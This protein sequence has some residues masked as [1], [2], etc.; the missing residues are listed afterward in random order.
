MNDVTA[1][2]L[3]RMQAPLLLIVIVYSISIVGL[4]MIPGV[5]EHGNTWHMSI[6]HALYFVSYTATTIGFGEIPYPM[7]DAQRLWSIAIIYM[8][9]ISWFYAL[10]TVIALFQDKQFLQE[11]HKLAFR[12]RVRGMGHPYYVVC[13]FGETG[14]AVVRALQDEHYGAVVIEKEANI[15]ERRLDYSVEYVPSLTADASE[16]E[17]LELA[18]VDANKCRGVIAVTASD[19]INLQIAI[20][21]KLLHPNV[22]VICRSD[23]K[24]HEDNMLSFGTDHIINPFESFADTFEMALHSPSTHLIYD[25]L[26]GAPETSLSTPVQIGEGHWILLGYGRFGQRIHEVLSEK[27]IRTVVVEPTES[28]NRFFNSHNNRD[29]FI[30]GNGTD[31]D[32]LQR[33]GIDS[34][35]GVIAGSNNDANNLSM[36]M[37]ARQLRND[38]FVVA[39]QNMEKNRRLYHKINDYYVDKRHDDESLKNLTH[40]T[41][42]TNEI[43]ARKIRALLIAPLLLEFIEHSMNMDQEWANVTISR[44]SAVIG[45]ERPNIWMIEVNKDGAP[46]LIQA[47]GYGRHVLLQDIMKHPHDNTALLAC[48]CL[49]IKRG[50]EFTL[51]PDGETELKAFDKLLFCGQ[52]DVKHDMIPT[53]NDLDRLN[54]AMT[55]EYEPEAYVWSQLRRVMQHID[56]RS[57]TRGGQVKGRNKSRSTENG[58]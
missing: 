58:N 8:T 14:R 13:G 10:G 40:L 6:F 44:L 2:F 15:S 32:S 19:E 21:S 50:D 7:T 5:D 25:W 27:G 20:S 4:L 23:Q 47:L 52:R 16:P 26:T 57:G 24:E 11:R 54:Y 33:A 28:L 46:G 45:D 51:L 3:R 1:F 9:V 12:R 43:I 48:V 30:V 39:R 56:R 38:I 42:Q 53:V 22:K 49:M 34:A 35:A 29:R 31:A 55:T 41:M 37:T 18:G 36:I 17:S